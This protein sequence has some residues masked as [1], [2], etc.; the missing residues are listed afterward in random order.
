MPCRLI[1]NADD[2]GWS[3][4]ANAAVAELYD[5][6][7]VT[8]TSLMVG[9]P[10]AAD[11]V[12]I[13]R[14][15][16]G[17][18]VGLHLALVDAVALL[19]LREI[20]ALVDDHGRFPRDPVRM[21]L[22][23]TF[24]RAARHQM[25]REAEA[26]FKAFAALGFPLSHVD[27][28]VH[29]ALTPTVFQT[30]LR[31]ACE[32]GARGFRVPL[33]DFALYRQL[34]PV[35]ADRQKEMARA[36]RLLCKGRRATAEARGLRCVERCYGFFRSGRLDTGYLCRLIE[37]LP[38]GDFELHC[39]PDLSTPEGEREYQALASREVGDALRARGVT[40]CTYASLAARAIQ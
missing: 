15:R 27:T 26:Q 36:F 4:G 5:R 33:D 8:S 25:R 1:L 2:F 3:E 35:D 30:A 21:G 18:A 16:S 34:D 32:H 13:L 23:Y 7:V 28:H 31:L 17:L 22:R 10:A 29:M 11:A 39:H 19:P 38:E 20:P 9:G 12:R 6:G 24:S 37:S 40:L 14:S